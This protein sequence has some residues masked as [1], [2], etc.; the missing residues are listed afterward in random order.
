MIFDYRKGKVLFLAT[1]TLLVLT[2]FAVFSFY[3][4]KRNNLKT[5]GK[6][7]LTF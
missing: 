2:T 6:N 4:S 5:K 1:F 3:P 7:K